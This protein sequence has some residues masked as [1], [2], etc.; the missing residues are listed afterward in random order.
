[1]CVREREREREKRKRAKKKRRIERDDMLIK[2]ELRFVV[3]ED[4]VQ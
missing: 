1:M 2:S 3:L 4:I